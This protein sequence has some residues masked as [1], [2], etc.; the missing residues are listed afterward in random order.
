[1][2][3]QRGGLH[4]FTGSHSPLKVSVSV[5]QRSRSQRLKGEGL[6]ENYCFVRT[7]LWKITVVINQS[8]LIRKNFSCSGSQGV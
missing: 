2:P 1:M 5:S 6:G 7:M 3:G 4:T 8:I